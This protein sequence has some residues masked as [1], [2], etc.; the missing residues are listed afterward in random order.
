MTMSAS[1][2][3]AILSDRRGSMTIETAFVAPLLA[4]LALGS[5][6]IGSVVSRQHELQTAAS[7]SESIALAASA[8]ATIELDT[9]EEILETSL[10]LPDDQVEV[11]TRFRCNA[12]DT[13]HT[14]ISSCA[15][16]DVVSSYVRIDI[17]DT[18]DPVWTQFG[19]GSAIELQVERLVQVS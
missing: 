8:G 1:P 9:L 2:I 17:S 14:S 19:V 7:E 18:Y 5:F 3:R 12:Q 13:L 16:D 4:L 10:S 6:E 15:E 11:A